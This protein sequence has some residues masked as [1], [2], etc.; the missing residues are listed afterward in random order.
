MRTNHFLIMTNSSGGKSF[1]KKMEECYAA[2]RKVY[3]F[4]EVPGRRLMPVFIFKTNDQF[5]AFLGK[6]LRWSV[7]QARQAKGVAFGDL[8]TTWY[9]AP[10]DLVHIHEA[11][12]QIF[13]NRLFLDGGGSWFQEG[14]AQFMS[15]R[16]DDRGAAATAVKKG[17]HVPLS[18]FVTVQSLLMSNVGDSRDE[19]NDT[20]LDQYQQAAL[21]IE[22]LNKSKFGKGKFLDAIHAFGATPSNNMG[23]I[24]AAAQRVYGVDLAGLEKQFVEYCKKR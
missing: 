5:Y 7:E 9:D 23:A 10:G 11:T 6:Q 12:H 15:T 19:S 4:D 14:V 20:A 24:Q 17:R 18:K 2:I 22:F 8:Y 1:A 21:F 16:E 13:K 3:P